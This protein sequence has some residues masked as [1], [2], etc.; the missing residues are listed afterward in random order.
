[1]L[2]CN[3][4]L[5]SIAIVALLLSTV[6]GKMLYENGNWDSTWWYP[7]QAA[8][9]VPGTQV[10]LPDSSPR[11]PHLIFVPAGSP[12]DG[13]WPLIVFLHGQGES[14]PSPLE[15]IALQGPPQHAGRHPASMAFAVLSP[16]KPMH[17]QF[18]DEEVAAGIAATIQHYL[19]TQPLDSRR[20]YLTGVSQ[21]GIGTWGL[22]SD[23]RYVGLFAAIAP[24]CGGLPDRPNRR[25]E[26]L[27]A[28]PVW[29]FHGSNDEARQL[30][31]D[32]P[33][34]RPEASPARLPPRPV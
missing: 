28:T 24:V 13:G 30:V 4:Q 23:P 22:A 21:G 16:Q 18:F 32:A 20:V 17:A 5:V 15:S 19:S 7:K 26:V 1:M 25:A 29:A 10:M 12:P 8:A 14:S 2:H 11:V 33:L 6:H 9:P 31:G 3:K 34:A 27:K